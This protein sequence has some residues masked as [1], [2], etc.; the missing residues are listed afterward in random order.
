MKL[1]NI[2]VCLLLL[3]PII[4]FADCHDDWN[5]AVEKYESEYDHF[6]CNGYCRLYWNEFLDNAADAFIDCILT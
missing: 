5:A 3:V 2:F 1:K 4:V 6:M